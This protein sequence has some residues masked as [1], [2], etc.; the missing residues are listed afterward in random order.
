MID[1][2][3]PGEGRYWSLSTSGKLSLLLEQTPGTKW[4]DPNYIIYPELDSTFVDV[5]SPER[6]RRV[7][8]TM[9]ANADAAGTYRYTDGKLV[10]E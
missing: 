5:T 3:D 7:A 9:V 4:L 2:P 10:K 8:K 1:L 6:V